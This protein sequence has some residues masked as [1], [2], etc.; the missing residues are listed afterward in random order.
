[1][2]DDVSKYSTAQMIQHF[3]LQLKNAN[4]AAWDAFVETFDV[5]ATE[6]AV[7]LTQAP[8]DQILAQQGRAQQCLA[9]LRT[10]RECDRARK[11]LPPEP[12]Q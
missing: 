5:Y 9:F 4:P 2:T 1:M 11:P 12:Q 3:A 8:A 7:A 6:A 10:L